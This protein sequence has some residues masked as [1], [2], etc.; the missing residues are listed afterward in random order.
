[1]RPKT[2]LERFRKLA[3]QKHDGSKQ[4]RKPGRPRKPSD[5]RELVIRIATESRSGRVQRAARV[6]GGLRPEPSDGAPK[7]Q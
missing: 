4:R 2:I 7:A 6:H 5:I 3:A 1:M